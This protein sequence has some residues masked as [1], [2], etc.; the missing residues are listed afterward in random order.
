MHEQTPITVI[1][2]VYNGTKCV[3]QGFEPYLL[4]NCLT[5]T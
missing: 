5:S 2:T 1:G 3:K 4:H